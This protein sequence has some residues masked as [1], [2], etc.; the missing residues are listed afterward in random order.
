VFDPVHPQQHL[1]GVNKLVMASYF[2]VFVYT[3][4]IG[5]VWVALRARKS[6]QI[7]T[8]YV[9]ILAMYA[10]L[11]ALFVSHDHRFAIGI[12]LLLACFAGAWL[13]HL[14]AFSLFSRHGFYPLRSAPSSPH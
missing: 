5:A 4:V 2:V 3:G 8:L 14:G 1:T 12:H 9:L 7:T 6:F 10:P 13:A 11:V